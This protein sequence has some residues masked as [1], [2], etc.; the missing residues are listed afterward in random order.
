MK[1]GPSWILACGH[2]SDFLADFK[3]TAEKLNCVGI[4][5]NEPEGATA[6]MAYHDF[7]A[8]VVNIRDTEYGGD[9]DLSFLRLICSIKPGLQII[10]VSQKSEIKDEALV[11]FIKEHSNIV[12]VHVDNKG[13][14]LFQ[15]LNYVL[16]I[17]GSNSGEEG[18][19]VL[20]DKLQDYLR[21]SSITPYFQPIVDLSSGET[22]A[23]ESLARSFSKSLLSHPG[24]LFEY[25]ANKNMYAE[26]DF[27]CIGES[28]KLAS[29]LPSSSKL[30]LNVQPRSLSDVNFAENIVSAIEKSG[31][32]PRSICI[33]LTEQDEI[34]NYRL[35][36][37]SLSIIREA[38][39]LVAIDDVG[40]GNANLEIMMHV[41][42][43]IVKF[44][45]KLIKN[46]EKV[47]IVSMMVEKIVE[48]CQVAGIS[49]VAESIESESQARILRDLGVNYG[50]GWH[51]GR[52]LPIADI[53]SNNQ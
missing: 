35:F 44:S 15:F 30:F 50:Q 39:C 28:L 18:R 19:V 22:F 16:G 29:R 33:E 48:V 42:P 6:L 8:L 25:A 17:P 3:K 37:A 9:A 32:D 13:T 7:S 24:V 40:E 27:T 51:F 36:H 47:P 10:I 31:R 5:A 21:N 43:D 49:N 52:P 11:A 4:I 12:F 53:D 45:G 41:Q 20:L 34:R 26:I 23:F 46:L 38:G 14:S 2:D 1:E